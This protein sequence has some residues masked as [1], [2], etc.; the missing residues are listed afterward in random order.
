MKPSLPSHPWQLC[1]QLLWAR[2]TSILH[3]PRP[4][5]H[6][7]SSVTVTEGAAVRRAEYPFA[8]TGLLEDAHCDESL[9]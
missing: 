1:L 5:P 7:P 9:V 3:L 4:P 6:P 2:V 8:Q